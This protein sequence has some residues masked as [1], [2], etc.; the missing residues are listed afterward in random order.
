M[1]AVGRAAVARDGLPRFDRLHARR[2]V[3]AG[4]QLFKIDPAA[5]PGEAGHRDRAERLAEARLK[6]ADADF[7]ALRT[8]CARRASSRRPTSTSSWPRRPKR[9]PAWRPPRR[10]SKRRKLNLDYTSIKS[11][12]DGIA[13]RNYPNVGDLDPPGRHAADDRRVARIRF[14]RISKSTSRPCS[15]SG[16]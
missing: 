16:G 7:D 1:R 3:E 14:T 13:G 9:Q 15:A 12:I 2:S 11:P 5:V 10:T 6:L 4:E 8:C